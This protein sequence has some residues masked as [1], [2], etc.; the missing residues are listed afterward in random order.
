MAR[1]PGESLVGVGES[2]TNMDMGR[3]ALLGV[4]VPGGVE[5]SLVACGGGR[6]LLE[7]PGAPETVWLLDMRWGCMLSD[8]VSS[9]GRGLLACAMASGP[10]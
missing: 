3:D 4:E 2:L 8:M 10:A 6:G 1:L 5:A 9:T 7:R